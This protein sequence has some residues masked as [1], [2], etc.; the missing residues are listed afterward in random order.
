MDLEQSL[1]ADKLLGLEFGKGQ[2]DMVRTV[3]SS[4]EYLPEL[5]PKRRKACFPSDDIE[6]S[7]ILVHAI[8]LHV[9]EVSYCLNASF[10][11]ALE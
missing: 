1:M 2:L 9:P 7:R 4:S 3:E 8:P 10:F 5:Y 11:A 6:G